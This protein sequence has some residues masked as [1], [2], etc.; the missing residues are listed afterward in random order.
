MRGH[1][2]KIRG[3]KTPQHFFLDRVYISDI[4]IESVYPVVDR[5]LSGPR[6]NTVSH[7]RLVHNNLS[8]IYNGMVSTLTR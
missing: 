7:M 4:F 1:K 3:R 5:M 2:N 8:E 6:W